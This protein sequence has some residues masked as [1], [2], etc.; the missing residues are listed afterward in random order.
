MT[1]A[2]F[3]ELMEDAEI[4]DFHDCEYTDGVA[5]VT[6]KRYSDYVDD[7]ELTF[8]TTSPSLIWLNGIQARFDDVFD[9]RE[10]NSKEYR[11]DHYDW[12]SHYGI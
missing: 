1:L 7:V 5:R 9:S 3:D 11:D 12:D 6:L 10:S 2:E 4:D 8:E